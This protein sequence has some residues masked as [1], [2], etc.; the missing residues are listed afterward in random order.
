MSDFVDIT[1]LLE[2]L[3]LD[4]EMEEFKELLEPRPE[5]SFLPFR[6]AT[7]FV[8]STVY[9]QR[10]ATLSNRGTDS[11]KQMRSSLIETDLLH[12][13]ALWDHSPSDPQEL[14]F[15]ANDVIEILDMSNDDWFYGCI[16]LNTGWF[17]ASF[18][19]L[20]VG[21]DALSETSLEAQERRKVEDEGQC[22]SGEG[23]EEDDDMSKNSLSHLLAP[24]IISTLKSMDDNYGSI[25]RRKTTIRRSQK[26]SAPRKLLP[27]E[28]RAKVV[29]EIL[30]TER[31]YIS[32]LEDITEGY[33]QRCKQHTSLFTEERRD[34]LFANAD[35]LL[36]FQRRFLSNLESVVKEGELWETCVGECFIKHK[37]DF[38]RYYS[39]YCNNHPFANS[40]LSE[41]NDDPRYTFFFE[42]CRL[43]RNM[44]DLPLDSFLLKPVQKICKYPLQ[45][46]ELL[47]YTDKAHP[48]YSA[49]LAAV[50]VMKEVAQTV[51]ERKRRVEN[52]YFIGKWKR[53]VDNW[54]GED[55]MKSSSELVHSGEVVK[56]SKGHAQERHFFLFDHQMVYCKKDAIGSRYTY[57]GRIATDSCDIID[58]A[59]GEVCHG[60]HPVKNAWK[61]NNSAKKKWYIL[62][63]KTPEVKSGWMAAFKRERQRVHEDRESGYEIPARLKKAAFEGAL[64]V[65]KKK[66]ANKGLSES[67][68]SGWVKG[69][70][71]GVSPGLPSKSSKV[72]KRKSFSGTAS[73]RIDPSVKVN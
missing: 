41:L 56:I 52:I 34:T 43:L 11:H 28:V 66:K 33:L 40:Q 60:G 64:T 42:S 10:A 71:G 54:E 53:S 5:A 36:Q 4:Q 48:D 26:E 67:E 17:P 51:N 70:V 12:A 65:G 9:S 13:D 16:E 25:R 14:P 18:V 49:V 29:D 6:K 31:E 63:A 38:P 58:L 21:Y 35:E 44:P 7:T 15:K 1:Q 46:T 22:P 3:L 69:K 72:S 24:D 39:E 45:L 62:Y 2:S 47:K 55:I 61:M 68:N 50:D 19:R 59:D 20:R 27:Q 8:K 57:K 32:S 23:E 37:E 73:R 30:N